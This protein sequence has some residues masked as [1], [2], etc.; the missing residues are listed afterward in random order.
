MRGTARASLAAV[1]AVLALPGAAGAEHAA[2]YGLV[3][4]NANFLPSD[5]G[6]RADAYRA[7]HDA[8]VR[9]IRL[10]INWHDVEPPGPPLRDFDFAERD[11]EVAMI[12]DAGLHVIG[13][14]AYGHPDYSA[15]GGL[16][17]RTPLGGGVPPFAVGAAHLVPPDDPRDF[18]RYA[19][20]TA[21]HYGDEVIAWEVWNEQNE[22]WRFWAPHEDP[23]A[24]ARLLCAAHDALKAADPDTPVVYGGVFF[25]AVA[26]LPGMSGPEFVRATYRADPRLGRCFDVLAYHPYPYPFTS[27]EVDVPIRGSVL[28]AA[29]EMRAALPPTDRHKPLWITEVGW[30]THDRSYGVSETKQAQYV[31]RMQAATFAQGLPVL[32]WYTYGGA[33]DPTGANQEA[34][35]GFFRPDGSPK[36]AV[37]AL[38]T[39][40]RVFEGAEFE[41]DL[42]RELGLPRGRLLLGGRGFA[43][44]YLGA[45]ERIVALWLAGESAAD[46]QGPFPQTDRTRALA[47]PVDAPEV[48]VVSHLGDERSVAAQDGR[49]ALTIGPGPLYVVEPRG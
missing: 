18:A 6:A 7:L 17:A 28:S 21:E 49:V 14:L 4:S 23:L 46:G 29:G 16:L 41:R 26:N 5:P 11:R 22:G 30:P 12:R 9:A 48:R 1:L 10:D 3:A 24:Y 34:W 8:G 38:S 44:E 2:S 13:L 15:L 39:F 31:A 35:F 32:T 37:R 25:P 43:L 47:L 27:P 36:P 20:A 42:S 33:E 40:T 45:G 19:A